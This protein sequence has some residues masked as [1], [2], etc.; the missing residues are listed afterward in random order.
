MRRGVPPSRP[1]QFQVR[2]GGAGAGGCW[3]GPTRLGPTLPGSA[4]P[5]FAIGPILSSL[6]PV[7]LG[8]APPLI[9]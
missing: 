3:A 8:W 5:T 9:H 2:H 7:F 1:R 6:G 4:P